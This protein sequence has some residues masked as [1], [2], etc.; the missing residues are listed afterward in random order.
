MLST[1]LQFLQEMS[2]YCINELLSCYIA[3]FYSN[4]F[5]VSLCVCLY[6]CLFVLLFPYLSQN[7]AHF[8]SLHLF[9]EKP[10]NKNSKIIFFIYISS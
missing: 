7:F 10:E 6:F 3:A 2:L 4:F 5:S 1:F 8:D 9:Y